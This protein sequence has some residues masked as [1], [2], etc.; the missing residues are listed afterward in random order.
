MLYPSYFRCVGQIQYSLPLIY[1]SG[2]SPPVALMYSIISTVFEQKRSHEELSSTPQSLNWVM[3][4]TPQAISLCISVPFMAC[5]LHSR[6]SSKV[7]F[8]INLCPF[9][10]LVNRKRS[11]STIS[12]QGHTA[13]DSANNIHLQRSSNSIY[14]ECKNSLLLFFFMQ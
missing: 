13:S 5:Q 7:Y 8:H 6:Y 14:S 11:H 12:Q 3:V 9:S 4:K 1:V 2:H 10:L